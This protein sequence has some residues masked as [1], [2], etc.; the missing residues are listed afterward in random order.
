VPLTAVSAPTPWLLLLLLPAGTVFI[1]PVYAVPKVVEGAAAPFTSQHPFLEDTVG[2]PYVCTV[3]AGE[4]LE[5]GGG[6]GRL[7]I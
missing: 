7:C 2:P 3:P 4:E 1:N 5:G 6:G